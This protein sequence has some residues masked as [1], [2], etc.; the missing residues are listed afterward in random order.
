V[1]MSRS[2]SRSIY[3]RT[4]YLLFEMGNRLGD[5]IRLAPRTAAVT[6]NSRARVGTPRFRTASGR[7]L[8]GAGDCT[9]S[10]QKRRRHAIPRY[11]AVV[12]HFAASVFGVGVG[13]GVQPSGCTR[14]S[15][16]PRAL[17]VLRRSQAHSA[18]TPALPDS[19]RILHGA[20]QTNLNGSRL[21]EPGDV[22]Q[23]SRR[24]EQVDVE[25][26][27]PLQRRPGG[28]LSAFR[29]GDSAPCSPCVLAAIAGIRTARGEEGT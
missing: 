25:T 9:R 22:R 6:K 2:R 14:A 24:D 17:R 13:V 27:R 18:R 4:P 8:A 21:V 28:W 26:A 20:Q 5:G 16:Q 19:L 3:A 7:G 1:R 12:L 15:R 29:V 23:A 10:F 11:T